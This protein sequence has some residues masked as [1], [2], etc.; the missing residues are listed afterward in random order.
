MSTL[1]S[2]DLVSPTVAPYPPSTD[3]TCDDLRSAK[4]MRWL[5]PELGKPRVLQEAPRQSAPSCWRAQPPP[6]CAV[7]EPT[8]VPLAAPRLLACCTTALLPMMRRRLSVRSPILDVA[9]SF[10]LPP[11]DL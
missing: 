4:I 5:R 9:P 6:T 11:V 8:S 7:C 10:C 2:S 3:Y 1:G